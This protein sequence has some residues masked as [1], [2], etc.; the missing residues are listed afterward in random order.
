V[1]SLADGTVRFT[2]ATEP[3]PDLRQLHAI[4]SRDQYVVIAN[5]PA[6][7]TGW[8]HVP[9]VIAVNGR[10]YGFDRKTGS[11][12]WATEVYRQG[13][14]LNQPA[15]LPVLTFLCH[16]SLPKSNQPGLRSFFGLTC[17][18]KRN[19]RLVVDNREFDEQLLFVEYSADSDQKQIDL[20]LFRSILRLNLTD[21]PYLPTP[22]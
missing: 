6:D 14:D 2:A 4:R 13:I 16:Y 18:D 19:G 12:L 5:Q 15:E 1:V 10:V 11:R 9:Q 8:Q 7:L 17:L 21:K 3:E 20:R 22:P